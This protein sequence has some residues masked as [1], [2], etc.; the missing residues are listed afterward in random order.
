MGDAPTGEPPGVPE[1]RFVDLVGRGELFIREAAGPPD[2]PTV[3]LLHG[4]V[5]TA[6]TNW[7]RAFPTL[8]EFHVVAPDHRGHGRGIRSRSRFSL[9]ECA[10]DVVAL[11]DALDLHNVILVGY[12]MGGP[13]A[14]LTWRRRPDRLGGLVLCSTAYQ[15]MSS[16]I[17][18][19][20]ASTIVP[21]VANATGTLGIMGRISSVPFRVLTPSRRP[22]DRSVAA[23]AG[24]EIRRHDVRNV[25]QA[26][27]AI[28]AYDAGDWIGEIDLPTAVLI[29]TKDR[30]VDPALQLRLAHRIKSATVFPVA[31]GHL[32]VLRP[33]FCTALRNACIEVNTRAQV[34][35]AVEATTLE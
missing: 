8:S 16:T 12:S 9:A 18:G 26:G 10:D 4:W 30:A 35:N 33:Q 1:A 7:F 15:F 3:V 32:G 19:L 22:G 17:A 24:G 11:L 34:T 20:A 25:L 29:T 31:D 21:A 23:W 5:G 13:I 6:A 28:S 14:Q 2:A 27:V